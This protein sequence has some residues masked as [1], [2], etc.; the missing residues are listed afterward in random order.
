MELKGKIV[1]IISAVVDVHFENGV[2]D[3]YSACKVKNGDKTLTLEVAQDLGDGMVKCIAMGPTDGLSRG[4][5]VTSENKPIEVPV[6]QETL[7]RI[8]NVLGETIDE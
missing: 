2:P 5:E 4:L 6:G 7:G 8:F 1:Q 3:I